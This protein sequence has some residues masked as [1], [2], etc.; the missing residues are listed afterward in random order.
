VFGLGVVYAPEA[1]WG[2]KVAEL[3]SQYD[4]DPLL[5]RL[6]Q[7][8]LARGRWR[9]V[10]AWSAWPIGKPF[11]LHARMQAITLDVILRLVFG[12]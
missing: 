3:L 10:G 11:A 1:P 8:R 2:P 4:R 6:E 7:N 12:A 5:E 9:I